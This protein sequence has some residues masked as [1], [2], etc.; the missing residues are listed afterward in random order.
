[1]FAVLSFSPFFEP[2]THE[3]QNYESHVFHFGRKA[4]VGT[5]PGDLATQRVNSI[6]KMDK[7]FVTGTPSWQAAFTKKPVVHQAVAKV[8]ACSSLKY[9]IP[10]P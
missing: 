9:G 3:I 10:C 7:A 6:A 5:L 1:M 4:V 2:Q 8:H